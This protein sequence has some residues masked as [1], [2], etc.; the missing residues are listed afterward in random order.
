MNL[1]TALHTATGALSAPGTLELAVLTAGAMLPA[2]RRPVAT[3]PLPS[4]AVV[5]P[6][7]NEAA[8]IAGCVASL[9]STRDQYPGDAQIFVV[10]DNCTDETAAAAA[11][12]GAE[13]LVRRDEERR[14][15]GWALDWAFAQLQ[16]RGF[17]A[18]VI[19]DADSLVSANFLTAFG[20][21]FAGGAA[22]AQCAYLT[23]NPNETA[24]TRLLDIALRAFNRLRPSG[25]AR[26]GLSAGI[27][28]NGF[29]LRQ[30]TLD[31]VPYSARSIVEDL[32]YHLHLLHAGLRVE[33]VDAAVVYGVMPAAGSGRATQRARWEGGRL[34][35][36]REHF[37]PLLRDM[38]RGRWSSV[39]PLFDLLLAPLAFHVLLL[40]AAGGWWAAAGF[41]VLAAHLGVAVASGDSYRRD[42]TALAF[43]P[44]YICWKLLRLPLTLSTSARGAVWVRTERAAER[45]S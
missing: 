14:G 26:W 20:E 32:E 2:R 15:K 25:R 1:M 29:A 43:V 24:A 28:G 39:E 17:D 35:M 23:A 33:W 37:L 6:A 10:A 19:V 30:S 3:R 5:V 8:S 18:F 31:T 4:L 41:T 11:G 22:A 12:A 42:L 27:L 40:A 9:A 16:G 45:N 34:R 44:V 36:L 38:A 13:V 7:H 21:C